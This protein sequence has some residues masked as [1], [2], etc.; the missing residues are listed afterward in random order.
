[1]GVT[2]VLRLQ[3]NDGPE[4]GWQTGQCAWCTN[5]RAKAVQC[6]AVHCSGVLVEYWLLY[7][8]VWVKEAKDYFSEFPLCQHLYVIYYIPEAQVTETDTESWA[9]SGDSKGRVDDT[10]STLTF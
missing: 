4:R 8:A 6:S 5:Y 3:W 1:M 2:L 9:Q 10:D 7:T